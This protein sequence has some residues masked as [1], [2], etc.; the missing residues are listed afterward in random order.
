MNEHKQWRCFHCDMVFLNP[1]HAAEHFGRDEGSTPACKLSSSE[2]HLVTYVRKLERELDSYRAENSDIEKAWFAK[3]YECREAVRNAEQKGYDMGV[4]QANAMYG[5][6]MPITTELL[7]IVAVAIMHGMPI[8][9]D[10]ADAR[11]KAVAIIAKIT[12][13]SH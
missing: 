7:R 5:D 6:V 8:T 3:D 11:N 2:G 13:E 10:V 9:Q 4:R 1:T 12:G